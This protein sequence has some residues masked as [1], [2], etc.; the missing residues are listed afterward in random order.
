MVINSSGIM[1]VCC[2]IMYQD[3]I[4][5]SGNMMVHSLSSLHHIKKLRILPTGALVV[6]T[7][8]S[9]LNSNVQNPQ[10]QPEGVTVMVRTG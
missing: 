10:S 8:P 3:V 1:A 4:S 7:P 2:L 9:I 6:W 5:L